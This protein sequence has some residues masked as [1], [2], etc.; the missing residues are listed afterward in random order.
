MTRLHHPRAHPPHASH[1]PR[2]RLPRWQRRTLYA[3]GVLLLATGLIWLGMH[4]TVGAG[5]GELPHPLEAWCLRL[6]GFAAMVGVGMFGALAAAH[7]PQGWRLAR[8]WHLT[9]QQR[10]GVILCGLA[11]LL[12]LT[13]YL[14]YYFAPEDVR[15]TLGVL[16][17]ALGVAMAAL[18]LVHRRSRA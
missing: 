2:H 3:S 13:G 8:R 7:V 4:Y 10:T 11:A 6:H 17:A 18:I 12:M 9:G 1:P 5:A 16:H 15:P 14:L